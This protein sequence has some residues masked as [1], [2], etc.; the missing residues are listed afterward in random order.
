MGPKGDTGMLKAIFTALVILSAAASQSSAQTA[1][2]SVTVTDSSYNAVADV[3]VRVIS[4]ECSWNCRTDRDGKF[5]LLSLP[6]SEP[7][8]MSVNRGDGTDPLEVKGLMTP[9]AGHDLPVSIEYGIIHKGDR[10]AV[11]LP[12]NPSTGYSWEILA[13]SAYSPLKYEERTF[14]TEETRP[15]SKLRAG[16]GGTEKLIFKVIGLGRSNVLL[17]YRR[18]WE[19]GISPVRYHICTVMSRIKH[20]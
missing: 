5:S 2:V 9:A 11:R 4:Q 20:K 14:E 3:S 6:P 1:S 15:G 12:S 10:Y 19:K 17:G 18:S 13:D 8:S 7:F 16:A